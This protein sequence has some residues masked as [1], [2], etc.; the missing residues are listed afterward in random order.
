MR[1]AVITGASGSALET[2]VNNWLT[3]QTNKGVNVDIKHITMTEGSI[4]SHTLKIV[5]FYDVR[6]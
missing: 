5:I 1:C 2:S 4:G 6:D 3:T